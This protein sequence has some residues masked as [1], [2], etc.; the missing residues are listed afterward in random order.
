M[1]VIFFYII[2]SSL[3]LFSCHRNKGLEKTENPKKSSQYFS[4]FQQDEFV[5]ETLFKNKKNG[6]FVDIGA[7]DGIS[8]SNTYFFEKKLSWSGICI[9]PMPNIFSKL[10]NNRNCI[11]I[12]GCIAD[13]NSEEEFL[14]VNGYSEM[15]SGLVNKYDPEHVKRIDY[16]IKKFG[17]SKYTI[18][19]KTYKLNDLLEE[20]NIYDIDLLSIDTEGGELDILKSIDFDK[21]FIKAIVVENNYHS[22]EFKRLL[23]SKGF[24]FIKNSKM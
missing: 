3:T 18:I 4:Q 7:H 13:K 2:I 20:H 5:N 10:K 14:Q 23:E 21:F 6:I 12:K 24:E 8:Y 11:C 17:G 16:E 19:V 9:E 1:R 15:L 22:K